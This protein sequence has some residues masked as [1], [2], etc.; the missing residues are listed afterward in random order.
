VDFYLDRKT[1]LPLKV[2]LISKTDGKVYWH[3]TFSEYADVGGIQ[4]PVVVH[5][6]GGGKLPTSFQFNVEYDQRIFE[7]P[8][9]ALAPADAWR[10]NREEVCG[11]PRCVIQFGEITHPR[12][13]S[14][15]CSH[16][17]I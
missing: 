17:R 16:P 9:S 1:R 4:M 13:L 3:K 7:R 5:L 8:P 2:A 11:G 12:R 10:E 15:C 14:R 6:G